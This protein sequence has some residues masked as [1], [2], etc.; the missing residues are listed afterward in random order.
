MTDPAAQLLQAESD[1]A[2]LARALGEKH[3][4]LMH[5]IEEYRAGWKAATAGG[6]AKRDLARAGFTDPS[7]LPRARAASNAASATTDTSAAD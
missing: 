1:R 2:A 5:V 4:S 7:R 6:W 3:T